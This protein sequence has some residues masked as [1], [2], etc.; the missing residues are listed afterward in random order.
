MADE[1]IPEVS[2]SRVEDVY[3]ESR[4]KPKDLVLAEYKIAERL[5]N[6]IVV[7][8]TIVKEKNEITFE[9]LDIS[10]LD[11]Y[12]EAQIFSKY[13]RTNIRHIYVFP[14][15]GVM[16]IDTYDMFNSHFNALSTLKGLDFY[17][18]YHIFSFNK[19][20]QEFGIRRVFL[21]KKFS[22]KNIFSTKPYKI[23]EHIADLTDSGIDIRKY[24]SVILLRELWKELNSQIANA[25]EELRLTV[26]EKKREDSRKRDLLSNLLEE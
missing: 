17:E 11:Y 22:I 4:E 13:G 12:T 7:W 5:G 19:G 21:R 26:E 14:I 23:E 10:S 6:A 25:E 2:Y 8:K 20:K 18:E 24:D 3:C 15:I 9:R 1:L 16:M